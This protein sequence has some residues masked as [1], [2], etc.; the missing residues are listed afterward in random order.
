[1]KY[2]FSATIAIYFLFTFLFAH[3]SQENESSH[4]ISSIRPEISKLHQHNDTFLKK[5]AM[6]KIFEKKCKTL[7]RLSNKLHKNKI[8]QDFP[9]NVRQ[10]INVH[11]MKRANQDN[12][13]NNV[14]RVKKRT[15]SKVFEQTCKTLSRL[16]QARKYKYKLAPDQNLPQNLQQSHEMESAL[17][18][19]LHN[20]FKP[21]Q[22]KVSQDLP[23]QPTNVQHII[24]DP[25]PLPSQKLYSHLNETNNNILSLI[26]NQFLT[27]KD[28]LLLRKTCKNFENLLQ[29]NHAKMVT[30]CNYADSR[31]ITEVLLEWCDLKYF[32]NQSYDSA[33]D[34]MEMFN[35]QEN[36]FA[37]LTN[38]IDKKIIT[39]ENKMGTR[40]LSK[41]RQKSKNELGI[42][43]SQ[44]DERDEI[45]EIH[46][47]QENAWAK[48]LKNG[49]VETGGKEHDGGDSSKVQFK[50][51]NVK[52]IVS[53]LSAFAALLENGDV[54]AWGD[55]DLGGRIPNKK[56]L[57]NVT[58]IISNAYAFAAL[59]DNGSV[60]A[61]GEQ[62]NGGQIPYDTQTKLQNIKMIF[63]SDSAFA[64]LLENGDV[65]AWGSP[66]HGGWIPY[67]IQ[68]KLQNVKMIFSTAPAFAALLHDGR[69]FAW[70]D[71]DYGGM[72]NI[73]PPL[74]NVKTIFS[75]YFSFS[76][77]LNDGSV[78]AWGDEN[79]GGEIPVHIQP[80]LQ[81]VRLIVS[82][83][84]AY[85]ALLDDGRVIA[86][87][88]G[89][90]G[91]I[92]F[93]D[94]KNQ[95]QNVKMIFSEGSAFAALLNDGSVVTWG[96]RAH[97]GTIP[98]EVQSK[99]MKNVKIIFPNEHGFTALCK[100]GELITW[101]TEF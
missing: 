55:E 80:K 1:M 98:A 42:I 62:F 64:A 39:W 40:Y 52:I 48:I 25:K 41:L 16:L 65:V 60:F 51:N 49:S 101:G 59:L 84:F 99:L 91:G 45:F 56:L 32:L 83:C 86:W 72:I 28:I 82:T 20:K 89:S 36:K 44:N 61:W 6:T 12:S 95:L 57:Q 11:E 7:F 97:G 85:A 69:V 87:G 46:N 9:Q 8:A 5:Y 63:S 68:T 21:I 77:L 31:K 76:A 34:K 71:E 74:Q 43:L 29:P 15:M 90:V 22:N 30:F 26:F 53:T 27:M 3:A 23:Q 73:E 100:T 19:K 58:T 38:T 54:V 66:W 70:G 2:C 93:E 35:I 78:F 79:D 33:F 67:D 50:L 75:N 24:T 81:N 4:I 88:N 13:H 94:V 37:V 47:K 14:T 96:E 17:S 92:I 18:R 10:S